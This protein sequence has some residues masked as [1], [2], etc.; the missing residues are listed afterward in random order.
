MIILHR[1]S[2]ARS[3]QIPVCIQI[4]VAWQRIGKQVGNWLIKLLASFCSKLHC[5]IPEHSLRERRSI[6]HCAGCQQIARCVPHPVCADADDMPLSITAIASPLA[7][8]CSIAP[9][10]ARSRVV[11]VSC[12]I[13]LTARKRAA[14]VQGVCLN[15]TAS[16]GRSLHSPIVVF[17]TIGTGTRR[18][19]DR[20]LDNLRWGTCSKW[21]RMAARATRHAPRAQLVRS[22]RLLA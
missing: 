21:L 12:A 9:R 10:A 2:D 6:H 18:K 1:S 4:V 16:T 5:K 11:E 15:V 14:I 8:V 13:A 19:T 7:P 3:P 22:H 20:D 17:A